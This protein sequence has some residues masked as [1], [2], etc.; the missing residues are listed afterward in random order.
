LNEF[1]NC[2]LRFYFHYIAGLPQPDEVAEDIDARLFGSVLHRAMK[3][4]YLSFGKEDVTGHKLNELLTGGNAVTNALDTALREELSTE[5][6]TLIA[7]GYNLI[8]L[9]VIKTY[10]LQLIKADKNLGPFRILNMEERF[11]IH[12]EFH[13]P[14]VGV[15]LGGIID[16]ID[17]FEGAIR[18]IDYKTGT[19]RDTCNSIASLF[20]PG[21]R[22]R[23]EAAF[24]LFLYAHIYTH[25]YPEARVMPALFS[26]RRSH[27]DDFS[28]LIK[29]GNSKSPVNDYSVVKEEFDFHLQ[30]L[31]KRLFDLN[32]P[33]SQTDNLS[34]C[35]Y[36]PY[37]AI[38]RRQS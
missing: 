31:I 19:V 35:E 9:H 7:E 6:S 2:S 24:Q 22:S 21:E 23:N 37:A 17:M 29:C 16:R 11:M 32:E 14:P 4:L 13:D 12:K 30:H 38:C 34:H 28:F 1:I 26:T 33:F 18:I 20:D 27:A 8:V 5:G 3:I 10:I 25:L 36:C 15:N